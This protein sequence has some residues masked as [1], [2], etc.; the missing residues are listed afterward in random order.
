MEFPLGGPK[1]GVVRI[2]A[3]SVTECPTWEL[4]FCPLDLHYLNFW[5]RTAL[6]LVIMQRVVVAA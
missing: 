5:M 6:F 4:N 2:L 3:F 1:S